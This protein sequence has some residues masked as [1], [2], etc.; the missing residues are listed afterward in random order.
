M[1]EAEGSRDIPDTLPS[2][3]ALC[4]QTVYRRIHPTPHSYSVQASWFTRSV[5]FA[6]VLDATHPGKK[7]IEH[8]DPCFELD[9]SILW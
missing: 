6:P 9:R 4:R 7:M 8:M 2:Q 3:D 5:P 1:G